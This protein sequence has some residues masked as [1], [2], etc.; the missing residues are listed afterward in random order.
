M[1]DV[2]PGAQVVPS[3]EVAWVVCSF[4]AGRTSGRIS[5]LPHGTL[6]L[7]ERVRSSAGVGVAPDAGGVL[8]A[9]LMA[10]QMSAVGNDLRARVSLPERLS[11]A[12]LLRDGRETPRNAWA[13]LNAYLPLIASG[14]EA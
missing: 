6:P 11:S 12:E 7:C 8:E 5:T 3:V 4:N 2:P 10:S 9:E 13:L 14:A 1:C